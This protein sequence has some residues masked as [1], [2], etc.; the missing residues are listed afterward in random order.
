[1]RG[2]A[3]DIKKYTVTQ[4]IT[5]SLKTLGTF[6]ILIGLNKQCPNFSTNADMNQQKGE[7]CIIIGNIYP[8]HII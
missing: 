6:G 3:L 8:F 7:L 5:F 1:M 2:H 4:K